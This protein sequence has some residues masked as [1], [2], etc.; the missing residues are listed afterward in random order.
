MKEEISPQEIRGIA[1]NLT[2]KTLTGIVEV[3]AAHPGGYRIPLEN[4]MAAQLLSRPVKGECFLVCI[5]ENNGWFVHFVIVE[6]GELKPK[7]YWTDID[8]PT[9]HQATYLANIV[10]TGRIELGTARPRKLMYDQE[11]DIRRTYIDTDAGEIIVHSRRLS[12][13]SL[14]TEYIVEVKGR[15]L[16]LRCFWEKGILFHKDIDELPGVPF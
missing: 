6:G 16:Y 10:L 2:G 15:S 11:A 7:A 8:D 1:S 5:R 13:Q 12:K 3:N 9:S 14:R 4:T